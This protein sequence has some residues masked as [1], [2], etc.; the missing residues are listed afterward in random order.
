MPPF[1]APIKKYLPYVPVTNLSNNK[2]DR[3]FYNK[4]PVPNKMQFNQ[5]IKLLIIWSR[6][7]FIRNLAKMLLVISDNHLKNQK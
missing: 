2:K 7:F 4:Y 1:L 6:I 5:S 3:V